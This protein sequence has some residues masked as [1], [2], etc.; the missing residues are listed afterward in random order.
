MKNQLEELRKKIEEEEENT[1]SSIDEFRDGVN[2][3]ER[4]D[5]LNNKEFYEEEFIGGLEKDFKI[6]TNSFVYKFMLK[7]TKLF[8]RM[9]FLTSF[10]DY[11]YKQEEFITAIQNKLGWDKGDEVE[12]ER[13]RMII[14]ILISILLSIFLV[15]VVLVFRKIFGYLSQ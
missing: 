6:G 1:K 15:F 12:Y 14:V 4:E 9:G 11:I 8:K 13:N 10:V 2:R 3:K 5:M 7:I